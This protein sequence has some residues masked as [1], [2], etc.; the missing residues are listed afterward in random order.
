MMDTSRGR[1]GEFCGVVSPHWAL[2]PV[3]GGK[4]WEGDPELVR[5][6]SRD[7]RMHALASGDNARSRGELL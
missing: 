2:R 4:E 1:V 7:E 6:A 3:G 5:E